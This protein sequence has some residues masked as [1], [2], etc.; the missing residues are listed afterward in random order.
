MEI[1]VQNRK[2]RIASLMAVI[3][4]VGI[5]IGLV[6]FVG[7]I[8]SWAF[9]I[10]FLLSALLPVSSLIRSEANVLAM[11][12][13]VLRWWNVKQGKKVDEGSERPRHSADCEQEVIGD[14][15]PH[16]R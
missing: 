6:H 14:R 7:G 16:S 12:D 15:G 5:G 4:L 2:G 8:M 1:I 3:L 11:S 9:A 10:L 13:G